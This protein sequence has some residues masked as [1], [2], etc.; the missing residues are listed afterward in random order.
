MNG[1]DPEPRAEDMRTFRTSRSCSAPRSYACVAAEILVYKLG[2]FMADQN[3]KLVDANFQEAMFS[4]G[5]GGL[6]GGWGSTGDRQ[7]ISLHVQ[8][9]TNPRG[10]K[11]KAGPSQVPVDVTIRP[12]GRVRDVGNVPNAGQAGRQ[13]PPSLL[14]REL[15]LAATIPRTSAS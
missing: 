3:A 14:C 5:S 2:G 15:K 13:I 6:L 11:S 9:C 4:I 7:P 10:K 8:F 1:A 12:R